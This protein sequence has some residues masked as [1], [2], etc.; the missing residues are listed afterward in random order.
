LESILRRH[1][2][3]PI[4][5]LATRMERIAVSSAMNDSGSEQM[6]ERRSVTEVSREM[7]LDGVNRSELAKLGGFIS[8]TPLTPRLS[9][10]STISA[11]ILAD[12]TLDRLLA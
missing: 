7:L 3:L 10:L 5:S 12:P 9:I 1:S 6:R 2:I 11:R 8:R 4:G